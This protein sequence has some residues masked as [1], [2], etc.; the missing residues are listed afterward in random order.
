MRTRYMFPLV[1]GAVLLVWTAWTA[2]QSL[3][4]RPIP[5]TVISG[6]NFGFRIEGLRGGT[7]VGTLVVKRDGRWVAVDTGT[8]PTPRQLSQR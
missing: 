3:A 2:T 1:V 6:E 7:P 4:V 8:G 5:P